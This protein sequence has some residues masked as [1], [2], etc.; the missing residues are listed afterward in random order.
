MPKSKWTKARI[1]LTLRTGDKEVT[2]WVHAEIAGLAV[3]PHQVRLAAGG[4]A[5]S[6][7]D[8]RIT[9]TPIREDV[10]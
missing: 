6:P 9:H 4:T 5:N 1:K 8:Y 2:S 3:T 7:G 10:Y